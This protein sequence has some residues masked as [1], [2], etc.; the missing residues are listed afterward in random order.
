[1]T[2][3]RKLQTLSRIGLSFRVKAYNIKVVQI[4]TVA[5]QKGLDLPL[6]TFQPMALRHNYT[7]SDIS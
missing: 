7:S 4:N 5:Q 2:G 1:M 6:D 3:A